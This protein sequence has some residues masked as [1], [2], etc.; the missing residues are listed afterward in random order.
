[1]CQTAVKQ[2]GAFQNIRIARK[3][4]K[5]LV[6]KGVH[7]PVLRSADPDIRIQIHIVNLNLEAVRQAV[8][9]RIHSRNVC[10]RSQIQAMIQAVHNTSIRPVIHQPDPGVRILLQ[11]LQAVIR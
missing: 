8:V 7:N 2:Q 1:M 6:R 10:S 11:N 4:G 9:I 5:G 3:S